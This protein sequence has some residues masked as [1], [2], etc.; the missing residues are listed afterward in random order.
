MTHEQY[1]LQIVVTLA[2]LGELDDAKK[3]AL[4]AESAQDLSFVDMEMDSLT[5]LDLC[6]NLEEATGKV[7]E[8]ADLIDHPTLNQL[9]K[10]LDS[11]APASV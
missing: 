6:V 10:F 11:A 4:L 9:A 3:A 2:E 8:P 7:V 5:A 1:R